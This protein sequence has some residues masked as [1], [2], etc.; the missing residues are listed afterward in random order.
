M[1]F[2]FIFIVPAGNKQKISLLWSN[3]CQCC[4]LVLNGLESALYIDRDLIP[5]QSELFTG[6][7]LR[8]SRLCPSHSD[9]AAYFSLIVE[10]RA[11]FEPDTFGDRVKGSV[12]ETTKR[13]FDKRILVRN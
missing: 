10:G 13:I 1:I 2:N 8:F 5:D 11:G 6:S 3:D 12:Q 7:D 4:A 9:R